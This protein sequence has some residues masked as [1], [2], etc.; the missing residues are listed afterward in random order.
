MTHPPSPTDQIP[1]A[2]E[3][4][5]HSPPYPTTDTSLPSHNSKTVVSIVKIGPH[6]GARTLRE[7]HGAWGHR[8]PSHSSKTVLSTVYVGGPEWTVDGTVFE[9]WLGPR[10]LQHR[11]ADGTSTSSDGQGRAN[12]VLSLLGAYLGKPSTDLSQTP[13][14]LLP[15][16]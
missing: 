11:S 8:P 1:P 16:G 2:W 9:M 13:A 14:R 7:H 15:T 12:W 6:S 4:E 5:V 3:E 10:G